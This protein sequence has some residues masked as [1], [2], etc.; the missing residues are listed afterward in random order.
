MKLSQSVA[1]A[2]HAALRLADSRNGAPVSCSRLAEQG[3]M[4]ERFLLQ[5]LRDLAKQGILQSTRGGGGGF[6][7][8]RRPEEISVLEVI[9]AV[10]GP[11]TAS[12]P[13]RT[14]FPHP[15]GERLHAVLRG[16]T[17]EVRRQLEAVKL[18]DLTDGSPQDSRPASE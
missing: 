8:D 14:R 3:K 13:L 5:I 4:P 7:L 15:A 6:A 16:I 18:S 11:L 1:Y 10:E 12:L 17:E 9:E 2:V